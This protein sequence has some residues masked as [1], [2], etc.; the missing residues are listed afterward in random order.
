ML[1]FRLVMTWPP[2]DAQRVREGR[3]LGVLGHV[4]SAYYAVS[5]PMLNTPGAK[6]AD[7]LPRDARGGW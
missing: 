3:A 6:V 1:V 4:D 2:E 7:G 5:L